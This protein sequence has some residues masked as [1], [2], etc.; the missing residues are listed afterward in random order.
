[1]PRRMFYGNEDSQHGHWYPGDADK[2]VVTLVH[3]GYWRNLYTMSMETAVAK[4]LNQR[5]Y[6]VWN[7][8]YRRVGEPGVRWPIL[9][10]DVLAAIDYADAKLAKA[11]QIVVSHSAG[12]TLGVWA[13]AQRENLL[14][15]VSRAGVLDLI[16]RGDGDQSMR[17]LFD[18]APNAN[19]RLV[20]RTFAE[21]SPVGRMPFKTPVRVLHGRKDET[22]P[23]QLAQWFCDNAQ[24]NHM[25]VTMQIIENEGHDDFLEPTSRSHAATVAAIDELST[26]TSD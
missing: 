21:A 18:L 20:K 15:A 12:S 19:L 10:E 24:K 6:P 14:G 7:I 13:A 11:G 26:R 3:G 25:D 23:W 8:E 2:P 22:V 17:L 4:D 16:E 5:G 9:G 1:M